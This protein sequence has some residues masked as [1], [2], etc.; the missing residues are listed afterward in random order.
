MSLSAYGIPD[1]EVRGRTVLSFDP[2]GTTGWCLASW[3]TETK[4]IYNL[5]FGQF[6]RL[7][8]HTDLGRF[9]EE[10]IVC[11][12]DLTVVTEDYRPEFGRAQN[13]IALEY[14]GVMTYLCRKNLVPFVRQERGLK[15]WW[16]SERLK[17]VG[18]FPRGERHARDAARH[19]LA[20]AQKED[21]ELEVELMN[22][23]R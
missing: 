22:K 18:F 5:Y 11:M 15:D 7:N 4:V 21:R 16:T 23:L 2:G 19:W 3:D 10:T 12:R 13:E 1:R 8:H 6:N 9:L 20:Y 14:I 17:K